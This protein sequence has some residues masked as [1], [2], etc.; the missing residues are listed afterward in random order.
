LFSELH[1]QLNID[2]LAWHN[3]NWR[4]RDDKMKRP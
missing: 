2:Q 1:D 4:K 3:P